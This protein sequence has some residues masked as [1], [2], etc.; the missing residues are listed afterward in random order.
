MMPEAA[1]G[2]VPAAGPSVDTAGLAQAPAPVE[3]VDTPQPAARASPDPPISA[4]PAAP[5]PAPTPAI[6]AQRPPSGARPILMPRAATPDNLEAVKSTDREVAPVSAVLWLGLT[7]LV[8]AG[9]GILLLIFFVR[10]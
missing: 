7:A 9:L 1:S 5:G 6:V 3:A 10:R 2:G 8:L 4:Q